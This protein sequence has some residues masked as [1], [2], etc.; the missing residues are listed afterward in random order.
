MVN[1]CY[2]R[3]DVL[4]NEG[5]FSGGSAAL[6][7]V[8]WDVPAVAFQIAETI[9]CHLDV[10]SFLFDE[11]D[12]LVIDIMAVVAPVIPPVKVIEATSRV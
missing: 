2:R 7:P 6:I 10:N 9:T 1:F 5:V 4:A 11:L 8:S 12:T 3:K